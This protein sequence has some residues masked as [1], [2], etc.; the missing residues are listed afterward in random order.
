VCIHNLLHRYNVNLMKK[1]K[2]LLTGTQW[3]SLASEW[4][5]EGIKE[6]DLVWPAE[7][8]HSQHLLCAAAP[9]VTYIVPL[10]SL[11]LDEASGWL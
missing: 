2:T 6:D 3:P 11:S 4:W 10:L 7:L 5:M 8:V 1:K 9:A